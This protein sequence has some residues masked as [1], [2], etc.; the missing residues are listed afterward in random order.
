MSIN[1]ILI[2]QLA[3]SMSLNDQLMII[4]ETWN[5]GYTKCVIPLLSYKSSMDSYAYTLIIGKD[6]IS[7][8]TL[9]VI[10]FL[11][12]NSLIINAIIVLFIITVSAEVV[13]LLWFWLDQFFSR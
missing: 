11:P 2:T 5:C 6:T 12:I 7:L 9:T 3:M 1:I 13:Q 10:L 4:T 8:Q